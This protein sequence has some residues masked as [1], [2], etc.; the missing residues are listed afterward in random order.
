MEHLQIKR[1]KNSE[2]KNSLDWAECSLDITGLNID[3]F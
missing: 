3:E 1:N 2:M